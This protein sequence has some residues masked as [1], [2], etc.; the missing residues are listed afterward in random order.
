M[1]LSI[2]NL[3]GKNLIKAINT[4]PIPSLTYSFGVVKWSKTELEG[5]QR[6]I[7]TVLTANKLHHSKSCMEKM[8]LPRKLGGRGLLDI[9]TL[10]EKQIQKLREYFLANSS[11]SALITIINEA[12]NNYTPLNLH[13]DFVNR[14]TNVAS[15]I[16]NW[17]IKPVHGQFYRLLNNEHVEKA[18]SSNWLRRG[19]LFGETEGFMIAIQDRVIATKWFRKHII[20]ENLLLDDKCRLCKTQP[21]TIDHIMAGCTSLCQ[22][23]FTKRHNNVCKILH[24]KLC[25]NLKFVQDEVPYYKY[26]PPPVLENEDYIIYYDR[27]ILTQHTNSHNRPDLTIIDKKSKVCSL[28][29]VAIPASNNIQK[30]YAEKKRKYADIAVE[31]KRNWNLSKVEIFPIIISTE[32]L[33]HREL[34]SNLKLLGLNQNIVDQMQKAVIIDTCHLVRKVLGVS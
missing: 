16:E 9:L 14:S 33:V 26:E 25:K 17:S 24:Q 10:H 21:E 23:E 2:A 29:D 18:S 15:K 11:N 13:G 32:G 27:T 6:T 20:K 19:N 34:R 5:L 8:V 12:D 28:I 3:N 30:S 4:Y 1:K 31:I 22:I 7:R